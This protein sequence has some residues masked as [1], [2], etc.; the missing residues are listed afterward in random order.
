MHN[1]LFST[2]EEVLELYD[3]VDSRRGRD[4]NVNVSREDLDPLLRRL[5]GVDEADEDLIAFLDA[6]NDGSFDRTIP[7][8]V[9]SGLP[10]G[11]KIQ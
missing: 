11:G 3:D 2:L 6:L 4:R 1:G 5:R 10:V 8:R 9:P 7:P